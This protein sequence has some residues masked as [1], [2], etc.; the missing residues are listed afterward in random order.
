VAAAS[1]AAPARPAPGELATSHSDEGALLIIWCRTIW[2][3]RVGTCT[4][5]GGLIKRLKL[6]RRPTLIWVP[7]GDVSATIMKNQVYGQNAVLALVPEDCVSPPSFNL[8]SEEVS[9]E[10][11]PLC[12]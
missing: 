11:C 2:S 3:W 6:F 7:S 8:T 9:L 12:S 1:A 4:R 10:S 5:P